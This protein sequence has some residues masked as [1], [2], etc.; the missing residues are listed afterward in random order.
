MAVIDQ[1]SNTVPNYGIFRLAGEPVNGTSGSFA[2]LA[3]K[4]ALLVDVTNAVLYINTNTQAS[5]T[6]TMVGEQADA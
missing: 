3:L 6:W 1:P 2:G 4:G 5:P